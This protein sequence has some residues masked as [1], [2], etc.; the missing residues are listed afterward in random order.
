MHFDTAHSTSK[1]PTEN[2]L[3]LVHQIKL[4]SSFQIPIATICWWIASDRWYM[5]KWEYIFQTMLLDYK[6]LDDSFLMIQWDLTA[7][8]EITFLKSNNQTAGMLQCN[9]GSSPVFGLFRCCC[10]FTSDLTKQNSPGNL[11]ISPGDN[12][13]TGDDDDDDTFIKLGGLLMS[14]SFRLS[15]HLQPSL[16]LSLFTFRQV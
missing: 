11:V 9:A 7:T 15:I 1:W 12:C 6:N 2:W 4:N 13:W 10:C 14:S 16:S 5:G 8:S 3:Q